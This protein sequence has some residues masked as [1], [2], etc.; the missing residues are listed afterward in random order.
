[1]ADT[2]YDSPELEIQSPEDRLIDAVTAGQQEAID[3]VESAGNA[4]LEGIGLAQET[5]ADLVTERIREGLDTQAALLRCRSLDELQA[6]NL[7]YFR[8]AVDQY[9]RGASR[10]FRL[11]SAVTAHSLTQPHQM[12]A[13]G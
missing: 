12:G 10:M 7:R 4:V 5:L 3:S 1:M 2:A 8:T 13:E 6:I 11:G 9:G